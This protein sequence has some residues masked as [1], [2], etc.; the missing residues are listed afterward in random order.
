MEGCG[1]IVR[2]GTG[3]GGR[4][5]TLEREKHL[6]EN[7][8]PPSTYVSIVVFIESLSAPTALIAAIGNGETSRLSANLHAGSAP[9]VIFGPWSFII[10]DIDSRPKTV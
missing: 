8:L 3:R 2:V 10:D 4:Q 5:S 6:F 1:I 9:A 7:V